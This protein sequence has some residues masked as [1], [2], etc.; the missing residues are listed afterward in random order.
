MRK[1][2]TIA[3]TIYAATLLASCGT[4]AHHKQSIKLF[5]YSDDVTI[6]VDGQPATAEQVYMASKGAVG[7]PQ[8]AFYG[9]GVKID[10]KKSHTLTITKG[11]KSVDVPF[12]SKIWVGGILLNMGFGGGPIGVAIDASTGYIK[13]LKPH[14]V[15]VTYRLGETKKK[16]H[17][18]LKRQFKKK[19]K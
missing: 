9:A 19:F 1:L 11:G 14:Y 7:G 13:N 4:I 17:G 5:N 2:V 6:K 18:K 16:S 3:V 10:R 8:V 15:D 12:K